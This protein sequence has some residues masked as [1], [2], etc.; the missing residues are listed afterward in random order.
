MLACR[1]RNN[2]VGEREDKG[3]DRRIGETGLGVADRL[4]LRVRPR[5]ALTLGVVDRIGECGDLGLVKGQEG[6]VLAR[7]RKPE[8]RRAAEDLFLVDPLK[9]AMK[10]DSGEAGRDRLY[11]GLA[12]ACASGIIET[13]NAQSGTPLKMPALAPLVVS[14]AACASTGRPARPARSSPS[15]SMTKR[16]LLASTQARVCPPP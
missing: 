11:Q 8:S 5:P 16:S 6:E 10:Q 9:W 14:R 7:R 4:D 15:E 2:V 12:T 13:R 3:L 1:R